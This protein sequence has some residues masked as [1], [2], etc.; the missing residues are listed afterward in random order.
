MSDSARRWEHP[1]AQLAL[2]G[3]IALC[4]LVAGLGGL[5][6]S[7]GLRDFYPALLKPEWTPPDA[8]FGPVWTALYLAM[9]VAAW[10]VWRSPA[11][12]SAT[13]LWLFGAQLALNLA[14]SGIFFSLHRLELAGIEILLLWVLILATM[15]SF[16]PIDRIAAYLFVPYLVWVSYATTLTW[17]IWEMN[18]P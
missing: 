10:R 1:H 14:W 15:I 7:A 6:T 2:A 13:P 17:A 11:R 3:F 18:R 8:I 5:M 4:F 16:F 9:A 12:T